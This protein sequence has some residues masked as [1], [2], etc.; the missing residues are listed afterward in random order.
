MRQLKSQVANSFSK[1]LLQDR[2]TDTQYTL[3]RCFPLSSVY[4]NRL[5][6]KLSLCL[7]LQSTTNC[8][9]EHLA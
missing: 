4:E 5:N 2:S 8:L 3:K 9:S 6:L 1:I 7:I